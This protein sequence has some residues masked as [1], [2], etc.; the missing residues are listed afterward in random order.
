MALPSAVTIQGPALT[1]A[2]AEEIRQGQL[3]HHIVVE[4]HPRLSLAL[5]WPDAQADVLG[6]ATAEPAAAKHLA[7]LKANFSDHGIVHFEDRG[8]Q[9]AGELEALVA[10]LTG[11]GVAVPDAGLVVHQHTGGDIRPVGK[12]AVAVLAALP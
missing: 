2:I 12:R 8:P 7:A 6:Y 5:L 9:T 1:W 3:P 10:A 4:C 11:L